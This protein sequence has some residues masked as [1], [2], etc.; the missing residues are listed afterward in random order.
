MP[1][2]E[3]LP[4]GLVFPV[5]PL[6]NRPVEGDGLVGTIRNTA[7]AIPAFIRVQDYWGFVFFRVGDKN[8]Y[9]TDFHAVVAAGTDIR[10]EN[11]RIGRTGYVR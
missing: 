6:L 10:I 9:L 1:I 4:R 11:D 7:A 3:D 8:I 5:S 2:P